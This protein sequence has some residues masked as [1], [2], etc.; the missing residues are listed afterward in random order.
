MPRPF[1]Y[2]AQVHTKNNDCAVHALFALIYTHTCI[3][4]QVTG[5]SSALRPTASVSARMPARS[6]LALSMGS[7]LSADGIDR[8]SALSRVA[9]VAAGLVSTLNSPSNALA[10]GAG[11]KVVLAGSTGQ[12]G[13][14]VLERLASTPG[15]IVV[16]GVRNVEKAAKSLSE[17]STVVRGAMV[18]KVGAVDT[19]AVE[20]K[21]LDVVTDSVDALAQ[22]LAGADSLVIATGFVPGNPFQ[23]SAAAH[24][25]DN[26]G[27]IKLIDAAKKAGV[28]KVVMVSSILTNGRAWGQVFMYTYGIFIIYIYILYMIYVCITFVNNTSGEVCWF[29]YHQRLRRRP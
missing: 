2:A 11:K 7:D 12:T 10:A 19:S 9:V 26:V 8:R 21:K 4:P 18:Q 20:L 23:M 6:L 17:S 24:D 28:K 29:C 1:R 15:L 16:G 3:C 14:R 5:V 13:R 27:C 22:T 25:V